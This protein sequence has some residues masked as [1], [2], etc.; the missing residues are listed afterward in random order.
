VQLEQPSSPGVEHEVP[1][2]QLAAA[3]EQVE[4]RRVAIGPLEHVL[5]L[6]RD[7]RQHAALG[8]QRVAAAGQLLL[9][10]Q[11]LHAGGQ[12]LVS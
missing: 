12:P 9:L 7:H 6:D 4:Q 8:V 2:D 3:F 11:Q 1:D 10:G 5:L